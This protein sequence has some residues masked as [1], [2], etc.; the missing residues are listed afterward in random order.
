MSANVKLAAYQGLNPV[1]HEK[2]RLAIMTFLI[3]AGETAF[4]D[5]KSELQV[6]DGN[7]SLHMRALEKSGFIKVRKAFVGRKPRTTFEV[8]DRG[9]RAFEEHVDL[10]ERIIKLGRRRAAVR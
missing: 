10:L 1:I 5:L 7:L 3:S 4:S 2:T 9:L 8:T 6:T